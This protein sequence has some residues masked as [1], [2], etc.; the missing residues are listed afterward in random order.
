[1]PILLLAAGLWVLGPTVFVWAFCVGTV[2]LWHATLSTGSFSH[3][4]G[5]YRNFDTP[6][7]SRNNRVIAVVLLGEGW[8][9]NH[10]RSPRAAR[11]G[12]RRAEPDPIHG[13]LRILA[14][15]GLIWD[16]QPGP[17]AQAASASGPAP[18]SPS[19]DRRPLT[20]SVP[21]ARS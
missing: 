16:L 11:H 1:M 15:V 20:S 21:N 2:A 12:T 17:G 8:H 10:H 14:A 7:D 9:N 3:R 13:V 18:T 5:G 4:I 19:T 6:D